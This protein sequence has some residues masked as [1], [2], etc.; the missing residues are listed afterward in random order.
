MLYPDLTEPVKFDQAFA[1]LGE[2]HSLTQTAVILELGWR[3]YKEPERAQAER[4][5]E[6]IEPSYAEEWEQ[7]ALPPQVSRMA[8]EPGQQFYPGLFAESA[9]VETAQRMTQVKDSI[10]RSDFKVAAEFSEIQQSLQRT[11]AETGSPQTAAELVEVSLNHP[12]PLVRVGAASSYCDIFEDAETRRM[13]IDALVEGTFS[14]ERIVY[15]LAERCLARIDPDHPRLSALAEPGPAP[16]PGEPSH[17]SLM[18]HGTRARQSAWWQPGGDFH[19]YIKNTVDPSLYSAADRYDWTGGY[20]N[21]A[22]AL[23]ADQL[24]DWVNQHGL[25]G[26]DLFAHSHGGNVAML[27]NSRGLDLGRLILLSCP[28]HKRKYFPDF[29][30]VQKVVSI[31]TR[32]DLIILA[33]RGG[34]R[35]RDSRIDEIVLPIWFKHSISHD[36]ATWQSHNL[37][38]QI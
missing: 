25:N 31:R 27:A 18:V 22:R 2:D 1:G 28:V 12:Q 30:R 16:E 5:D 32:L 15:E 14:E 4:E 24:S 23:A 35:F 6:A 34:Q 26:L 19:T 38:S 36:P 3:L 13:A 11:M 10:I 9:G 17:T 29:S 8:R 7:I 33:D 21:A 37:P 20:S